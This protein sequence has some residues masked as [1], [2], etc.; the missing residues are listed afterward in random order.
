MRKFKKFMVFALAAFFLTQSSTTLSHSIN[1]VL[2]TLLNTYMGTEA[3][4]IGYSL[5]ILLS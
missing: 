2:Y 5:Q 4:Y 1:I 3:Q